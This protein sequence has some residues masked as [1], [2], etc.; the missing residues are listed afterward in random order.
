MYTVMNPTFRIAMAIWRAD[1]KGGSLE[2]LL[3]SLCRSLSGAY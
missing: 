1:A 3:I 2:R